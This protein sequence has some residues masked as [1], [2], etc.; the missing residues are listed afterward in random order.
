MTDKQIKPGSP[1]HIR[2]LITDRLRKSRDATRDR[3]RQ[4]EHGQHTLPF[5]T[6]ANDR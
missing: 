6:P 2:H 1:D 5:G 3:L 4:I